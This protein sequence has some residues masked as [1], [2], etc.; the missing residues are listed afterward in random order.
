MVGLFI[1][2]EE[3]A[4]KRRTALVKGLHNLG[5]CAA[6]QGCHGPVV[7]LCVQGADVVTGLYKYSICGWG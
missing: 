7:C 4:E 1:A 3:Y 2:D 5:F 6:C